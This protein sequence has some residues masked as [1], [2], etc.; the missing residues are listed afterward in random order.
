MLLPAAFTTQL[1]CRIGWEY[2]LAFSR[3]KS[4][5]R[6][7]KARILRSFVQDLKFCKGQ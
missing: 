6:S 4:L 2:L 7:A 5:E 3:E 1:P